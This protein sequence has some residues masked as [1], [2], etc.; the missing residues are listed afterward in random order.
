MYKKYLLSMLAFMIVLCFSSS[1]NAQQI[2]DS[3]NVLYIDNTS[4]NNTGTIGTFMN[5]PKYREF[6]QTQVT[7]AQTDIY[8]FWSNNSATFWWGGNSRRASR[9]G[10]G[11]NTGAH[12]HWYCT[13]YEPGYYLVYHNMWSGNSTTNAYVKFY[14]FGE[15][16]PVDSFR[17]NMLENN[18]IVFSGLVNGQP[19]YTTSQASSWKPL[20]IVQLFPSDSALTV[21][22]G[23]DSLS[24]NT[25]RADAIALV[26]STQNGPDLEFGSRRFTRVYTNTATGDTIW[27]ES[28]YK[29]RARLDF[30]ETTF[31]GNI[32]TDK[33]IPLYNLGSAPLIVSGFA[34]QTNRFSVVTPA[35][36]TIP[37]GGKQEIILRFDPLGEEVTN[38]TL[39]IFSNDALEPEAT[40][41]IYG[42][43]INYNF[44]LNA[45]AGGQE[46][47]W[48]VPAPG[49][50]Y[51]EVGAFLNSTATPW[52]YPI[53]GGN[54]FSRVNTGSDPNIAV[55]YKFNVPDS[56][57]GSSFFLE[58]SGPAGSSNAAQN[59]TADVVTPFYVNPDPALGDTQRVTNI[60]TRAVTTANL[61]VR[62]GGNK[63]FTLNGG[64]ET[65]VRMTNP[66]QGADLL[67]A[68]LLRVRLVPIAPTIS[69]SLDDKIPPRLL[70]F[71]SV[72][73]YDSIRLAQFNYQ[74][75][76]IV[77]SNGETPL[78]ID[79]MYLRGGGTV[80]IVNLPT[81]PV[82]LPAID[83][84]LNVVVQFLPDSIR[85][86]ADTLV[87]VSN[88]PDDTLITVRISGQGV[89]TGITVDD[90]DPTTYIFPP[91]VQPWTG[92]PDPLNMDKW[93]LVSGSGVNLTRM[94]AY[95][96]FNPPTG[97][98]TLEWYPDIPRKPGST[99][100]EPD[101]FD[102]YVQIPVNSPNSSPRA[103]YRINHFNGT[104]DTVISQLNRTLNN[105]K[106]PLGRYTFLRGGRDSH[107]SGTVY[108]SVYLINDTALVS[109]YYQDS[110]VNTARQ[111]SFLIR[112]DA[113]ILEQ[114]G[115]V[116]IFEPDFV[117]MEYSLSQNYPNPFNPTTQI[118]YT[119]PQ[120]S[121]VQLK[122][123]DVLGREIKTLVNKEQLPGAYRVEWDGTNNYGV[124]VSSGIYIYRLVA[125]KFVQSKKMMFL[126]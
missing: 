74:R 112:A 51:E 116:G 78:R 25:L 69:T 64:G 37:P 39:T 101:S 22:I 35:P 62:F 87:I 106:I 70:N 85:L 124:Q 60:N 14:R 17:Y 36:F 41:P 93:Y 111:D 117:P 19:T 75:N 86:Y 108:G 5:D 82:T 68:D 113:L 99:T 71:G 100:D 18:V 84:E 8:G 16:E 42:V 88:D 44:I 66:N 105:G 94:F 107:G 32:F 7:P 47:H 63:V 28:F 24:G 30:A 120:I 80:S 72:S 57:T 10:S 91:D 81:F 9:F 119:L 67:R 59:V 102:V 121:N 125:G 77:G 118:R 126:K 52:P 48:N 53:P 23:L 114:A 40:L 50:I 109:A 123:Y 15:P 58:Y 20:G 97:L 95:I 46:P 13:V 27:R 104:T 79:T 83:G 73:I 98:Q 38:D 34:T 76:F 11:N 29:D 103:L 55:F 110:L 49:G 33:K 96:Y 65:V 4:D 21:E 45:S 90:S 2:L 26:R 43:G 89:G 31:K 56:L 61:W 3:A 6:P 1:V 54:L 122:I 115:V 92:A 12:V